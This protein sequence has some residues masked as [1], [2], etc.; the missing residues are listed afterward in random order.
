M[1]RNCKKCVALVMALV[2]V[3][4]CAIPVL[5]DNQTI[6]VYLCV[7]KT[8]A[9]KASDQNGTVYLLEPVK[10]TVPEGSTVLQAMIEA[11]LDPKKENSAGAAL[12]SC[13]GYE[14]YFSA[15]AGYGSLVGVTNLAANVTNYFNYETDIT[16][17]YFMPI[18]DT[19]EDFWEYLVD[20]YEFMGGYKDNDYHM[21]YY[22]SYNGSVKYSGYLTQKDFNE[23]SGWMITINNR[24][25][26][27]AYDNY[28]ASQLNPYLPWYTAGTTLN[29]GDVIRVEWSNEGGYDTDLITVVGDINL[30]SVYLNVSEY[31]ARTDMSNSIIAAAEANQ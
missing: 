2:M 21:D 22:G 25:L 24:M 30:N 4:I 7:E 27:A 16:D 28:S 15:L 20:M 29:D 11:G 5:A 26:P 10:V 8:L 6:E 18:Y 23:N 14:S 3:L 31:H 17:T 13:S 19:Y 12:V 1:I 9:Y